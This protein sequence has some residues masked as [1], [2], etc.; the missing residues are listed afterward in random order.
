MSRIPHPFFRWVPKIAARHFLKISTFGPHGTHA[1]RI[2][3]MS[4]ARP[5]RPTPCHSAATGTCY[6]RDFRPFFRAVLYGRIGVGP[7]SQSM[8]WGRIEAAAEVT[9]KGS[10]EKKGAFLV[11]ELRRCCS[12]FLAARER[13]RTP[14]LSRPVFFSMNSSTTT[15]EAASGGNGQRR[16]RR[17]SL[18]LSP[19]QPFLAVCQQGP[20]SFARNG[21]MRVSDD[22]N[23]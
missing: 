21:P 20:L 18:W 19:L 7:S 10:E 17:P 2:L 3:C 14:P 6:S 12:S 23:S 16:R 5:H 11:A 22:N 1:F 13:R 4:P 9:M 8:I 15:S